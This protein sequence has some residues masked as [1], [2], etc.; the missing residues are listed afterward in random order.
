M[1]DGDPILKAKFILDAQ[2]KPKGRASGDYQIKLFVENV[3]SDAYA[4]TYRLDESYYDPAR[5]AINRVDDFAEEITSY[6]N[7]LI[8]ARIRAKSSPK[9][10][11][12]S[13]YDALMDFHRG[14]DDPSIMKAL[15][16]I[17]EN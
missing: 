17:A 16:D 4:V 1:P 5:E 10:I 9:E 8:I 3:P 13:L 11:R 6:G 15:K 12:R 14:N 7:Y 2:G